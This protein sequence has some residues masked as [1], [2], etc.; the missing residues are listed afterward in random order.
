V[1]FVV[2]G[3]AGFI[4]SHLVE[5]L[6][7]LGHEVV[8]VDNFTTGKRHNLQH[9]AAHVELHEGSVTDLTLMQRAMR[10]ADVVLHQAALPSVPRS[11]ADPLASHDACSTGTLVSLHAAR[12]AGVRRFI[13]AGSS[14]AY[15][16]TPELPKHEA[17]PTSPRSPYAVAKLSG[18]HY[19]TAFR[20]SLGL[21]AV[22]LRYFNVFG[23]RQD[24]M[25]QYG[26]VIPRMIDAALSGRAPVIYGDGE[27]SRDF[28]FIDNVVCAN[29]LACTA[30]LGPEGV[31]NVGCGGRV[32]LNELWRAISRATGARAEPR[33]EPGRPGDVRHSL[34]S[35]DRIERVLGYR[36]QVSLDEGLRRTV[37]YFAKAGISTST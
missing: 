28:T 35:L 14:S 4:G 30:P 26:A 19:C 22:T 18:E 21:E 7:T 23:P 12:E 10:G 5:Q 37:E 6:L 17:M 8:V 34:A 31:F 20:L 9:V 32:T 11:L 29:M 24:V 1:R 16:D 3:G 33:Y 13:Y 2:T 36:P 27:Q 15:G 25:S